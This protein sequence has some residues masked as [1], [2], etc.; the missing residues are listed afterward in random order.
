[1][2]AFLPVL[3]SGGVPLELQSI[4]FAPPWQE[5]RPQGL[6]PLEGPLSAVHA[7]RIYP[8][9]HFLHQAVHEGESLLWNPSEGL[10]M[11]YYALWRTRVLSPFSLPF[12]FL[13]LN[14]AIVASMLLKLLVAGGCAFYAARRLGFPAAMALLI[15]LAFQMSGPVYLWAGLP[16]SDVVP[17]LPLLFL[18]MERLALGQVRAWAGGAVIIALM[19]LGG[20]PESLTGVLLFALAYLWMRRLRDHSQTQVPAALT[21]LA[22]ATAGGLALTAVQLLPYFEYLR[23]AAASTAT[24]P[25]ILLQPRDLLA[26]LSPQL[27]SPERA[28]AGHVVRLLFVGPIQVL[29]LVLWMA[30]RHFLTPPLR[31]RM[32]ALLLTALLMGVAAFILPPLLAHLPLLRALGPQHFLLGVPFALALVAAA[33]LE[34]WNELAPEQCKEAIARLVYLIP[35]V[36]GAGLALVVILGLSVAGLPVGTLLRGLG[37]TL[38]AALLILV[39]LGITLFRPGVRRTGYSFAALSFLSFWLAFGPLLA[40]TEADQVFPETSMIQSLQDMDAR[41]GGSNALKQWPLAGNGIAQ[42]FRPSGPGVAR[43]EAF[44]ARAEEDPLLLR[45]TGALALLLTRDDIQGAYASVRPMLHIQEVHDGVILFH[46]LQAAPRARMLYNARSVD[47]FLPEMLDSQA[48]PLLEDAML[49]EE[50][51]GAVAEVAVAEETHVRLLL[52][53]ERTNPGV[54][55]LADTWY[56]GWRAT[57]NGRSVPIVPV[58]GLFRGVALEEGEHEVTFEYRP[59]SL[60]IGMTITVLSAFLVLFYLRHLLPRR[61][62]EEDWAFTTTSS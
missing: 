18:C 2:V 33:A 52:H 10:G 47:A 7:Q 13:A 46:D 54:L 11:P 37:P 45:R 31:R 4:F 58:D 32:E 14:T 16:M 55:V 39:M 6:E 24:H 49:P 62:R 17:W 30:L 50:Y 3:R 38:L 59:L 25:A 21:G 23:Q 57:V 1:M 27:M 28:D 19:A 20:D 9:R 35:L 12:Y 22:L 36:W 41:V 60:R 26:I 29:L 44:M 34:E 51:N 56:P 40:H 8:E 5:A 43:Y 61:R 48:P 15:A 42:V 53:T